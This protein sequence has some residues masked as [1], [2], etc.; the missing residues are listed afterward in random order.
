MTNELSR[1]YDSDYFLHTAGITVLGTKA[2]SDGLLDL[3]L[4]G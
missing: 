2:L 1:F 4:D 3:P